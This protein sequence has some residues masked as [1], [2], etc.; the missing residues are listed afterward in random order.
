M[1]ANNIIEVDM[2]PLFLRVDHVA[3]DLPP[4]YAVKHMCRLADKMGIMICCEVNQIDVSV[5]PGTNEDVMA[6]RYDKALLKGAKWL[7]SNASPV[8][9]ETT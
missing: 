6:E 3:A 4:S 7:S 5:F 1:K 8:T 2:S 9:L